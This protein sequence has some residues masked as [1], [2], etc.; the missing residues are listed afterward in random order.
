[1][2]LNQHSKFVLVQCL[3]A[4]GYDVLVQHRMLFRPD[5]YFLDEA[6]I[7]DIQCSYMPCL[8]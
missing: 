8:Y 6:M 2:Y 7:S 4:H 1:M 3:A 5:F